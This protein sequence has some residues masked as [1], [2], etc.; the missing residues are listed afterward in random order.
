M[1]AT[2]SPTWRTAPSASTGCG[3][4]AISEPSRF[5]KLTA[6]GR[7]PMPSA[8]RSA[9]VNTA[10]TPGIAFAAWVSIAVI[11]AA[12]CGLRSTTPCSAPGVTMSSV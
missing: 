3:G 5:L 12:A 4:I 7:P 2:G 11:V 1:K 9:L 6:Q 10:R 8:F